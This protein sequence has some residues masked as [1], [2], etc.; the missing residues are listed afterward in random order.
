MEKRQAIT[1][2]RLLRARALLAKESNKFV[3]ARWV[4]A[5]DD[6]VCPVCEF[7][8]SQGWLPF[9][10]FPDIASAH[11]QLG[12]PNWKSADADCRCTTDFMRR[13]FTQEELDLGPEGV[14]QRWFDAYA[15]LSK[16]SPVRMCG[17]HK[18]EDK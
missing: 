8:G 11:S 7:L 15:R 1:Y 10:S 9:D 2:Q 13:T 14:Q 4:T 3:G 5:G 18:K 12:G 17:C 16:D 6:R